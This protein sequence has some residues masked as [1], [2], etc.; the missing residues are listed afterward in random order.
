MG[1]AFGAFQGRLKSALLFFVGFAAHLK[2]GPSRSMLP[3]QESH[4]GKAW[5]CSWGGE[6]G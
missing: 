3:R 6:Q 4:A 5:L 1:R 2:M